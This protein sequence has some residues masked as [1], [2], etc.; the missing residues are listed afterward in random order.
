MFNSLHTPSLIFRN[1]YG[2]HLPQQFWSKWSW[3]G[4]GILK[5][6]LDEW[7][8]QVCGEKQVK[9][10]PSYMVSVDKNGREFVRICCLCRVKIKKNEIDLK[11]KIPLDSPLK[12]YKKTILFL[13]PIMLDSIEAI[14]KRL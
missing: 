10:F 2:D 11:N 4:F 14:Q 12:K 13:Y 5:E 7:Y 3:G 1:Q 8:C 9:E 6:E